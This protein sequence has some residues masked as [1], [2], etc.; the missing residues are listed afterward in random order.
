MNHDE[1]IDILREAWERW[2]EPNLRYANLRGAD[3]TQ[4]ATVQVPICSRC[5][6]K[7]NRIKSLNRRN[8][9]A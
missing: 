2:E 5:N 4:P 7:L 6:D 9:N 1:V 3:L 8:H